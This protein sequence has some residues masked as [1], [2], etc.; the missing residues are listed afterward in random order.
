MRLK[1]LFFPFAIVVCV[2]LAIGYIWPDFKK[3]LQMKAEIAQNENLLLDVQEKRRNIDQLTADLD[4]HREEENFV[5]RYVPAGRAEEE[6]VNATNHFGGQSGSAVITVTFAEKQKINSRAQV[7]QKEEE[8]DATHLK[9]VEATTTASGVYENLKR[10]LASYYRMERFG[11]IADLTIE[12][13]LSGTAEGGVQVFSDALLA[14]GK[15]SYGYA[16]PVHV[17][18]IIEHPVFAMTAFDYDAIG[19]VRALVQS[20]PQLAVDAAG[21]SNPFLP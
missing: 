17:P 11:S 13:Q 14:T 16:L 6:I 10:F 20:A 19:T 12:K 3:T 8:K 1:I 4:R 9:T 15:A 2:S 18:R 21:R 5:M 7:Q